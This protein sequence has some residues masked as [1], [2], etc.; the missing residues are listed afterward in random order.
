MMKHLKKPWVLVVIGVVLGGTVLA[1][2]V[3]MIVSK[4]KS[5]IPGT[6]TAA[7]AAKAQGV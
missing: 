7:A 3:A 1:G 2:V 5:A 4:V 6:S